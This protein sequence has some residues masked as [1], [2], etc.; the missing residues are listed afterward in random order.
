MYLHTYFITNGPV[1]WGG[2]EE[3]NHS[4][5]HGLSYEATKWTFLSKVDVH[6]YKYPRINSY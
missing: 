5:V 1:V 6:I 3:Y 2:S 4:F